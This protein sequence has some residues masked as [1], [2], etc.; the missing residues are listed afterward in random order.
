MQNQNLIPARAWYLEQQAH[1]YWSA[2]F[3]W[4]TRLCGDLVIVAFDLIARKK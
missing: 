1:G 2:F 3:D 4:R